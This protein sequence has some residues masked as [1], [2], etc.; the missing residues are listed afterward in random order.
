M[1]PDRDFMVNRLIVD[2][3]GM[4]GGGTQ[5]NLGGYLRNMYLDEF[6][7]RVGAR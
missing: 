6:L 1:L 7:R 2:G 5:S 3:P 4:L